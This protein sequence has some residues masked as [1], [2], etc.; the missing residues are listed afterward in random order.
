MTRSANAAIENDPALMPADDGAR[1][2]MILGKDSGAGVELRIQAMTMEDTAAFGAGG[3]YL[4]I[5]GVRG[6]SLA[7]TLK[8][9]AKMGDEDVCLYLNT[10]ARENLVEQ[11][12]R[13]QTILSLHTLMSKNDMAQTEEQRAI[14]SMRASAAARR[15]RATIGR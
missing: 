15:S 4:Q 9:A 13:F 3:V 8:A 7:S 2:I 6:T 1:A 11:L 10:A 12:S 14:A 5:G